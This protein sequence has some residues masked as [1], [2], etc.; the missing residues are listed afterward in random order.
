MATLF[1]IR[2]FGDEILFAPTRPVSFKNPEEIEHNLS[3]MFK[4]LY[5]LGGVGIAANQCATIAAPVPSIIIAGTSNPET[6][7]KAQA[8]YPNRVIP[9]AQVYIN[10]VIKERSSE[11]YF[12]GEG[13]LSV[14]C[15]LRGKVE[16]HR[17]IVMEYQDIH[18]KK[19]T[20]KFSDF[21][22]HILQHE[23]DHL[24]G[25]VFMHRLIEDMQESQRKQF[26]A[27][28]DEVLRSPSPLETQ[29]QT[30]TIALDRDEKGMMIIEESALKNTLSGLDSTVLNALR[31]AAHAGRN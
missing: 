6:I 29:P 15:S 23:C 31:R 16:R 10:P 19:I 27:L 4:T 30:P 18:G 24:H 8:R 1:R 14:P 12:P 20:K 21:T 11:T 25:I 13:C 28:I 9:E 7:A 22:A 17:W 5:D 2:C 26:V 3:I